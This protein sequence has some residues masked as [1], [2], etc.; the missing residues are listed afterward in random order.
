[1]LELKEDITINNKN[2]IKQATIIPVEQQK[3][4]L[5]NAILRQTE[6]QRQ[7]FTTY[8]LGVSIWLS[9]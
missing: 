5:I 3:H 6:I 1:V 4:K 2:L 8:Q 7:H 9:I